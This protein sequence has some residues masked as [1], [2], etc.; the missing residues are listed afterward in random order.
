MKPMKLDTPRKFIHLQY[1][2]DLLHTEVV[3]N[4]PIYV[5]YVSTLHLAHDHKGWGF[6]H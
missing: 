5:L 6:L 4:H 1:C 2:G 3:Y